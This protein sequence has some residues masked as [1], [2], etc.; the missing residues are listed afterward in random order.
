MLIS[1]F[2]L[3]LAYL[4][5]VTK[6]C[7]LPSANRTGLMS[8]YVSSTASMMLLSSWSVVTVEMREGSERY[9][10]GPAMKS[11]PCSCDIMLH[12]KMLYCVVREGRSLRMVIMM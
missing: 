7:V 2:I 12:R 9:A 6:A 1:L 10:S 11:T 4:V 8:A 3:L 5:M